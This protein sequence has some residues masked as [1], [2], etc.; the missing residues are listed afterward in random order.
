MT[1]TLEE[2]LAIG[3][4]A[5]LEAV[6]A[7][8]KLAEQIKEPLLQDRFYAL[9]KDE[10]RHRVILEGLF[11]E[12]FPGKP[13]SIP[14]KSGVPKIHPI[15]SLEN[16]V[17]EILKLAMDAEKLAEDYYKNLAEQFEDNEKKDLLNYLANIEGGHYYFLKLE[18]DMAMKN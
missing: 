17:T 11:K 16:T 4:R 1:K 13:M 18:Y 8:S 10:D 9:A 14:E 2:I 15:I 12:N 3:I 7:Y 6:E 5:E